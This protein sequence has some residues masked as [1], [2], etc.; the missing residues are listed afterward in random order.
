MMANEALY[1]ERFERI[2]RAIH[3]EQV[4]RVPVIFMAS[5]FAPRYM[6]M[7]MSQFVSDYEAAAWTGLQTMDGIGGF[8]GC[9]MAGGGGG[10]ML[11]GLWLSHVKLPGQELP[12]DALWQIEEAEVMT[13]ADYD[14]I[15]QQGWMPW[16]MSYMPR[17]VD[18]A[19]FG[20][21]AAFNATNG[22]RFA[23]G[24]REAGYVVVADAP[25]MINIPY[26]Y[27]CGGRS[28]SSGESFRT[29]R[30]TALPYGFPCGFCA[31][32]NSIRRMAW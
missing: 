4:D 8:D 27:F 9:Q 11:A 32:S 20:A 2:R 10:L 29:N 28:I 14:A 18:M 6:G 24:Y 19:A 23:Q 31:F 12:D 22:A 30:I 5:A 1:Q 7:K 21:Q 25:A 3:C 13:H 15:I 16:L 26:E 17:V